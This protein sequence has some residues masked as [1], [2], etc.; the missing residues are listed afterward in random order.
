MGDFESQD[1]IGRSAEDVIK[2]HVIAR[3]WNL[4]EAREQYSIKSAAGNWPL[5]YI[6]ARTGS[7][8]DQLQATLKRRLKPE[9]YDKLIKICRGNSATKDELEYA[10]DTINTEL[11]IMNI[12]RIDG[13]KKYDRLRVESE[14]KAQGY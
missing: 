7:V 11:D 4:I 9:Q 13:K 6:R 2:L 1:Y 3:V 5:H 8:F 10:F 14:N 12:T